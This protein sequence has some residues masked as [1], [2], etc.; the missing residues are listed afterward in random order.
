MTMSLVYYLSSAIHAGISTTILLL[1]NLLFKCKAKHIP[2]APHGRLNPDSPNTIVKHVSQK[3]CK[4]VKI[5][6]SKVTMRSD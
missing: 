5:G 3:C 1:I 2:T 4:L 6:A